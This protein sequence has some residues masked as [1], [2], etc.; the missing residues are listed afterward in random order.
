VASRND[1]NPLPFIFAVVVFM[2][3]GM[4]VFIWWKIGDDSESRKEIKPIVAAYLDAWRDGDQATVTRLS[5]DYQRDNI[6]R[7]T[8][9]KDLVSY[10]GLEIRDRSNKYGTIFWAEAELAYADGHTSSA[11]LSMEEDGDDWQVCSTS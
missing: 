9:W 4:P 7:E 10:S 3:C 8:T 11:H 5:C 2:C 6:V 1:T